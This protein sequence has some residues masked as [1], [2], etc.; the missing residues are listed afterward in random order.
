M[1]KR[2]E[3]CAYLIDGRSRARLSQGELAKKL[4]T[5]GSQVSRW[6]NGIQIPG[7]ESV[8]AL[9]VALSL[10]R[11]VLADL[12][13]EASREDNK[14]LRRQQGVLASRFEEAAAEMAR[15]VAHVESAREEE[16]QTIISL[17]NQLLAEIADLKQA[18]SEPRQGRR[19]QG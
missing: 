11:D 19:A 10:D 1:S 18:V 4:D 14:E 17:M 2:N 16:R 7:A 6:E 15:T 12:A 13:I 5:A 3:L 8:R 9:A